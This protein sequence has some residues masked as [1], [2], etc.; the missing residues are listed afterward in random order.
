MKIIVISIISIVLNV[1][2]MCLN[3]KAQEPINAQAVYGEREACD[4]GIVAVSQ[5]A[6][7]REGQLRTALVAAQERIKELE[8]KLPK[9]ESAK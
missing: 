5:V 7:A 1:F 8:A 4:A 2:T 6:R 3:A 9:P